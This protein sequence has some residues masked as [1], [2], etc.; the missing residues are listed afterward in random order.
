MLLNDTAKR[1]LIFFFYD[2]DGIIDKYVTYMLSDMKKNVEKII[3]V[4]N[5]KIE[6]K[7]RSEISSLADEVIERENKG[8]D[9]W[10]YKE[11]LESVGWSDLKGYDEVILMNSTIMGPVYPFKEMF[12][13]MDA[14]DV[15]FWGITKFHKVPFDPFGLIK[16]GYIPEHIQSHFIAVRKSVLCSENFQKYWADVPMIRSYNESVAYHETQFTA[17]FSKLGFKWKTYVDTDDLE[18]FTYAPILYCAKKLL[19]EKRCP[20]FK[21]RSFMH[22]YDD[23]LNCS[24]GETAYELMQYLEEKTSYDTSLIWDNILRCYNM[25]SI[26]DCLHLNY[27][28]PEKAT[29]RTESEKAFT[30]KKIALVFHAYFKDLIKST[31]HYVNSM[32]SQADIYITT[33]TSEKKQLLEEAFAKHNFNKFEIILIENRGRDVSALLVATKS[34]IMDYDY[35]CF[36]HDKKVSQLAMGSEGASFAYHCL[37]NTL[38][39]TGYVENIIDLFEHN[40]RLGIVMPPPPIHGNY[41]MTIAM[42]WGPNFDATQAL[43]K[44]LDLNVPISKKIEPIAPLGTMFWFRPK[45]MKKLFDCDWEYSDFP[46]EPNDID[47]TLLHAVERAYAYVEQDAGYY[48]AWCFSDKLASMQMTNLNYMLSGIVKKVSDNGVAGRYMD[49]ANTI[50]KSV[51][52]IESLKSIGF[53]TSGNAPLADSMK[54][55]F[56]CGNGLNEED[57]ISL[58]SPKKQNDFM[59]H[60]E[61]PMS[62]HVNLFRFDPEENGNIRLCDLSIKMVYEDGQTVK[63][64]VMH[65][66]NNG[67]ARG[68]DL[69]FIGADPQILWIPERKEGIRQVVISGCIQRGLSADNVKQIFTRPSFARRVYRL[70]KRML[71]LGR[72][73]S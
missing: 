54:L 56:D 9:V 46:K 34:F 41:F 12:D 62:N 21:R 61:L 66:A 20:I 3:F 39:S 63:V 70:M 53:M 26:K 14:Q 45:G 25:G 31:V 33:D 37:E 22:D 4:S 1:L 38:G 65:A 19:E 7:S 72:K 67:F 50:D 71:K 15:D 36:A 8:L 64:E 2:K 5:G 23:V 17:H 51:S 29:V 44:K 47:G 59:L 43:I 69:L 73:G 6:S 60:F 10:A 28:L 68:K 27:I 30:H 11:A 18:K 49:V 35:V 58:P 16:C 24:M 52:A 40:P 13:H 48:A 32:P 57:T 55:Y 42:G